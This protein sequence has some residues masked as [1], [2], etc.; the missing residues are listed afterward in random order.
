MGYPAGASRGSDRLC[1]APGG[2]WPDHPAVLVHFPGERSGKLRI[3]MNTISVPGRLKC[4]PVEI[5]S[6][7]VPPLPTVEAVPL[8]M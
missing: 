4:Q 8:L 3:L 7:V 6:D 1:A 5:V 2:R